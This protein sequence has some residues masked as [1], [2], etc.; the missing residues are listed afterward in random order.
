MFSKRRVKTKN[1]DCVVTTQS[2]MPG[3]DLAFAVIAIL[4]VIFVFLV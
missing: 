1:S 2:D 3:L 4:L